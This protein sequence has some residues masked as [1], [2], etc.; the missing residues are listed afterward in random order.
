MPTWSRKHL[1]PIALALVALSSVVPFR[2]TVEHPILFSVEM[3][4]IT[5]AAIVAQCVDKSPQK[6][7]LAALPMIPIVFAVVGRRWA[8]P[9]AFEITALTTFGTASL[10]FAL[11]G[12]LPRAR[13]LSLVMSG[14]LVL[15]T[16]SISESQATVVFPLIWMLG[17]VWH[18]IANH[19]ERLDLAMPDSVSRTWSVRPATILATALVLATG[20][21]LAKDELFTTTRLAFGVMPTSGGSRWSDPAARSGVGT[22][23][24]AIAAQDRADSFGAVDTDLFLESTEPTLFDMVNEEIGEPKVS[25]NKYAQAQ[26]LSGQDVVPRHERTARSERGGGSFSVDRTARKK[27]RHL[28][29]AADDSILQWDGPVGIRLALHRYDTFDGIEWSQSNDV[30]VDRFLRVIINQEPWFFDPT[31]RG[32]FMEDPGRVSVGLLKF[33]RLETARIPAPMM[34]VGLRIKDIDRADFFAID[35]DGSYFMP[36]RDQVPT[37]TVAHLASLALMEDEI[38]EHLVSDPGQAPATVS[39][40]GN[41]VEEITQEQHH[42]YDKLQAVV[43]FLRSE[44]QFDR[45]ATSEQGPPLQDFLKSRRG[46]DHLF[47]TAAAMMARE[48]GLKSRL[49]TGFYVRPKSY[50]VAAS[51]ASVLASDVHVWAEIQLDDGRWFEIEPTPGYRQPDYQ[52]SLWLKSRQVLAAQWPKLAVVFA[53][54][55]VGVLTRRIWI[56]WLLSF[57]W[58]L[59]RC[60]NPRRRLA[61]AMGVIEMRARLVGQRRPVGMAQRDWMEQLAHDDATVGEAVNRYCQAADSVFFGSSSGSVNRSTTEIVHLLSTQTIVRLTQGSSR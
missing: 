31:H 35:R 42:P 58:S 14:A 20:G 16:A 57:A 44:F 9:I 27:H 47:A 38:R 40:L 43:G 39:G 61:I 10:A 54:L 11:A 36:G 53:V 1:E 8:I 18:L 13:A 51:H 12:R 33:I 5:I 29:D 59:S 52:P 23:D 2:A 19:W 4:A 60:L 21:Y 49:V 46:G 41:L 37:L 56:E 28:S 55:L 50:D 32:R 34:T 3:V 48:L 15:F 30:S 25:K 17:C 24:A 45:D 6:I 26:A 7:A 22:G